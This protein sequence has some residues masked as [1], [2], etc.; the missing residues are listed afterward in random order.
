MTAIW[1]HRGA[2]AYAP[3]NTLPAFELAIG[4]GADGVEL[5]VQRT[6]DGQVVVIHDETV[7]RTSNGFGKV[8]DQTLAQ[9][10][11]A[12]FSNGFAGRRN[13]KLPTLRD[14]YDLLRGT[15]MTINV[16]LKNTIELYPGIE[17][18]VLAVAHDAGM[19]DQTL[20]SS[21]NH[22]GLANLRGRVAREQLAILYDGS[23]YNPWD[24]AAMV[25]AGAI[26]PSGYALQQPG[27]VERCHENDVA[28][29]VWTI[30]TVE[31]AHAVQDL[32]VDAII[33]DF[34][35]KIGEAVRGPAWLRY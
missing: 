33:T 30:N 28:V 7:N 3:E 6:A 11:E 24:Y 12:D 14:V 20:I 2:C 29:N 4:M 15:N 5:D 26:H 27:L 10:R 23:L 21:F 31:Q 22:F 9:L 1:A 18:D 35:D 13:V 32:G 19:I 8:V 17:D 16:E 25:G 34:P